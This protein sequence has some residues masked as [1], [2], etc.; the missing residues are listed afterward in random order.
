MEL[1]NIEQVIEY[2]KTNDVFLFVENGKLGIKKKDSFSIPQDVLHYLKSNK[3]ELIQHIG[4]KKSFKSIKSAGDYGLPKKITNAKLSNFLNSPLHKGKNIDDVYL[5]TP[6]QKGFSF[7]NLHDNESYIAQVHFDI[8]GKLSKEKFEKSWEYLIQMHTTL[9][10]AFFMDALQEPLQCVYEKMSLPINEVDFSDVNTEDIN[11]KFETLLAEDRSKG[12]TLTEAPLLRITLV[13]LGN[14]TVRMIFTSHHI[15]LD[16]W[17]ITILQ[18]EFIMCYMSLEEKSVLPN[19]PIDNFGDYV[20]KLNKK[21]SV[22]ALDYWKNYLAKVNKPSHIPFVNDESK[23]NVVFANKKLNFA[24]EVDVD[25]FVKKHRITKNTLAQG[26][27]S[28]LLSKYLGDETVSFGNVISGRGVADNSDRKVGL[29]IN[30]IPLCTTINSESKVIDLL[31]E[32]QI[33]HTKGREQYGHLSLSEIES[34]SV[35]KRGLF[36][37]IMTVMN[38]PKAEAS[39]GFDSKL[40]IENPIGLEYSNYAVSI[41]VFP[42][43]NSLSFQL[44]YNDALISDEKMEMVKNHVLNTLQSIVHGAT[45]IK[46]INYLAETEKEYLLKLSKGEE[47]EYAAEK[48]LIASFSK[49]VALHPNRMAVQFEGT[50]LSYSELDARSNQLANYLQSR[51][52]VPGNIVGLLLDRSVNMI[53]GILGVLKS[54]A[55][56]VPIDSS[57]PEQRIGY[58]IK[59]SNTSLLLSEIAYM[60]RFSA[61]LPVVNIAD[62]SIWSSTSDAIDVGL[63]LE[64]LAY[65]IFT[66][67][68][69][70]KPKGVMMSHGSVL[71][72]VKGLEISVYKNYED[73]LNI[74]LLAS[75]AFDASV[76]QI[77]GGLLLGHSV[78]IVDDVSR[79]DGLA[80]LK[81]YNTYKIQ[82]SDGTP[83]HLRMLLNSLQGGEILTDLQGWILA[84]EYLDKSLVTRFYEKFKSGIDMYNFYGPTETCVD[85][86]YFK[87]IPEELANYQTIPIGKALPNERIYV[88]DMYGSLVAP[89]IMGELC[90][91]G[92]GLARCYVGNQ[93]M[94][95]DRFVNDWLSWESRVY[96]TG[97]MV[98][99][100]PDG[101]LEYFGRIDDQVKLR[102]Y[103]IELSEIELQL[104]TISEIRQSVVVLKKREGEEFLVGYYESETALA[105]ATLRERLS[106]ELPDYMLPSYY[107]HMEKFPVNL[108]GKISKKE[109]PEFDVTVTNMYEAAS[110]ET[111]EYLVKIWAEVLKLDPEK[112]GVTTDFFELGGHSLNVIQIVNSISKQ[113]GINLKLTEIFKKRTIRQTSDLIEMSKWL[114]D[115]KDQDSLKGS[116]E[117]II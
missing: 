17:S 44:V 81:F 109:L 39:S 15:I 30:T 4:N 13:N 37:T 7:H 54:G 99:W 51:G 73:G 33:E 48:N 49:Q 76:Q 66:S 64:D 14:D 60:E 40:Q 31:N 63:M 84:G 36:D 32:L 71:N 111:E 3:Q 34:K 6:L 69:S 87:I 67:G 113:F 117:T 61:Y 43:D 104:N 72:L 78:Y 50:S 58:M 62:T 11:E 65:C 19:F 2:L 91:A 88:T 41:K 77:F 100:L 22:Q 115:D 90:I 97:D 38:F 96:R 45:Y 47:I 16:G 105:V 20:R 98:R 85:S 35:V 21:G 46:D 101:N 94:T 52:I 112:I 27:W 55:G 83:T 26:I 74:C 18:K 12:F 70:G 110:N 75:Y 89:G 24:S 107:V 56:Y 93:E 42:I 106:K 80:L 82:V 53:V 108:S 9:R 29:Y 116:K 10:T 102:G 68:S 28:F 86:T 79:K 114:E 23:R 1:N 103:R 57:L 8:K 95:T 59:Q 5:L 25:S 92:A